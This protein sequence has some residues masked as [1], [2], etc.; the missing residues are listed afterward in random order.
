MDFVREGV[1][2]PSIWDALR[3]QVFLGGDEFLAKMQDLL[4]P[5]M[6]EIPRAQRRPK[7]LPL[8]DGDYQQ[9]AKTPHEAMAIAFASGD[10]PPGQYSMRIVA[11]R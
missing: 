4:D 11:F 2:L 5:S 7:A 8:A 6:A 9:Q 10:F 3:G 1:G